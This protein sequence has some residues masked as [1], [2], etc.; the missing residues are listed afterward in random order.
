MDKALTQ[1]VQG[2]ET[3][4]ILFTP[5][6]LAL[7]L[8]TLGYAG[9]PLLHLVRA[10]ARQ[11]KWTSNELLRAHD[12]IYAQCGRANTLLVVPAETA[13]A[14]LYLE[15]RG[16]SVSAEHKAMLAGFLYPPPELYH[17]S[18]AEAVVELMLLGGPKALCKNNEALAMFRDLVRLYQMK[19]A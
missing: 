1:V 13:R 11:R 7:C 14:T 12:F 4:W 18:S 2:L 3:Q 19:R 10:H 15:Y 8:R 5:A 9:P 6:G 17:H 16:L